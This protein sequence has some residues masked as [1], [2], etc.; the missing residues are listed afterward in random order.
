MG[1][2]LLIMRI[3]NYIFV[4]YFTEVFPKINPSYLVHPIDLGV[5]S[6]SKLSGY[7]VFP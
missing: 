4:C 7:T 1:I 5:S 6:V 2:K 3:L